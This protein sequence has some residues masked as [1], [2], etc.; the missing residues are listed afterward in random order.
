[1]PSSTYS[2]WCPSCWWRAGSSTGRTTRYT[3]APSARSGP[4]ATTC[5]RRGR[6]RGPFLREQRVGGDLERRGEP[7]DLRQR[8]R[9]APVSRRLIV[10]PS[11]RRVRPAREREPRSKRAAGAAR[12]PAPRL[13]FRQRGWQP[14][15]AEQPR[16]HADR[17]SGRPHQRGGRRRRAAGAARPRLPG[18]RVGVAPPAA[19]ARRRRVP[20]GRDRRARLRR[21][22]RARGRRGV[23][24]ARPRGRQR[25]GRPRL[26]AETAVVVGDDWGSPIAAA[27]A[28]V[29]PTCS[30]RSRCSASR[31]RRARAPQFP[32]DFYVAHFQDGRRRGRDRSRARAG[33]AA[34]TR[35][36]PPARRAGSATRCTCPTRRSRPGSTTS[37]PS[38]PPSSATASPGRST[39]IATSSATGRT[40]PRSTSAHQPSI[41][42]TGERDSTRLVGEAIERQAQWMP[43]EGT[44]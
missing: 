8:G 7:L 4:T 13:P 24:D 33:C 22:V 18:R 27:S 14:R 15:R 10:E 20:R 28:Q 21:L 40:S 30:P 43:A 36:S 34:S 2:H 41:F 29:R 35:R 31:T 17:R 6:E 5:G 38:S 23:P 19:R 39:A 12:G 42:I 9:R 44:T 37:T 16:P 26:E 3:V 32:P 1:M 11:S 25:R